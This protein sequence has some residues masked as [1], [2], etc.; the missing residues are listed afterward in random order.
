MAQRI[1]LGF[2][3]SEGQTAKVAGRLA[4]AMLTVGCEVEL[5]DVA[6]TPDI[7]L[8]DYDGIVLG[9]SIHASRHQPRMEEFARRHRDELSS[10]SSAFFSVSL[11]ASDPSPE[12]RRN[13][14]EYV[15]AFEQATGWKPAMFGLFGGALPFSQYGFIKRFLMKRI[16]ASTGGPT[17]TSRDYE[18]TNWESVDHFAQDFL[19]MLGA[20]P[21]RA[22]PRAATFSAMHGP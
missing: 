8:A 11:S 4:R 3:T 5:H 2:S 1:F 16:L 13:A 19:R 17:D 9:A 12:R 21:V 18:F 10:K 14:E 7:S 20:L 22:E 6:E 15:H